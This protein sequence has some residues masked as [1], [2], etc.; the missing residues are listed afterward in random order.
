MINP[1]DVIRMKVP[2]PSISDRLA[3]SSHMYICRSAEDSSKG[4]VKCQTLKP[5]MLTKNQMRHY[6]DEKPDILRNPF[7]RMTR[8][9]CDKL[10]TTDEVVYDTALRIIE[11]PDICQDLYNDM[12]YELETDGYTVIAVNENE[13][14]QLNYLIRKK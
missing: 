10:F 5:Y 1:K 8:L 3:V 13:L 11:R 2:Y 9:D 4:F 12:I 6:C 7:K 14:L